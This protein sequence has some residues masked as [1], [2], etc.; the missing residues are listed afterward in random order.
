MRHQMK[1]RAANQEGR[2]QGTSEC[3]IIS[4]TDEDFVD[5]ELDHL[6]DDE[7]GLLVGVNW[8]RTPQDLR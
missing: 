2:G 7:L 4:V 1:S 8:R 5:E 6:T 3:V